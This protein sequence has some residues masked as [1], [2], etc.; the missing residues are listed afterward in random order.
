MKKRG[1]SFYIIIVLAVL[2]VGGLV[3]LLAPGRQMSTPAVVLPTLPPADS[4]APVAPE[5]TAGAKVITV[6]PDTAQTVIGTLRRIDSYSRTLDIRDFWSGGSRSRQVSVWCRGDRLRLRI[7]GEDTPQQ[8]LL[9]LDGEL[10][11]WYTE[12]TVYHGSTLPGDADA[13]QT[14]LTY[15]DMLSVPA[16][17]ILDAGYTVFS[18]TSCIFVRWR[19]GALGY[20]SECYIDPE[21]GLLMGERC[22]DGEKLIY[23]MDSSVPDV[24]TPDESVFSLPRGAVT[25][26]DTQ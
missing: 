5:H 12:D 4:S 22:Y 21:T 15:E 26:E 14:I 16:D 13:W 20:V 2:A 23:S 8:E 9:F 24:T 18:G 25:E 17:D 19:S 1:A 7:S 3:F 10:W 11:L 6:T